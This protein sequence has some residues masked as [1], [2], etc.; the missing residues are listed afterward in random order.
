MKKRIPISYM[1]TTLVSLGATINT[2]NT[3][4]YSNVSKDDDVKVTTTDAQGTAPLKGF[5]LYMNNGYYY[6]NNAEIITS[7]SKSD[8]IRTNG[9]S[10]YFYANNLKITAS[11]DHADAI[12]MASSNSNT[13]Y[14]D[15]IF[16]KENTE[17]SSSSGVTVRANNYFNENSKSVAILSDNAVITNKYLSNANNSSDTQGYGVYAGNRDKDINNLGIFD[18]LAGKNNNTKG[19]SYIFISDN[20]EIESNAKKGHAVY[21]NKG[22]TIQLGDSAKIN[23]NGLDAYAIFASTEQQGTYTDNIRPGKVYLE[24]GAALRAENSTYVIQAKG[25]DSVIMSGYLNVPVI[26]S[27]YVRG[28]DIN[29]N[30]NI[31][32]PSSG[33]FDIKGNISAIEGGYVFL[34]MSNSSK[35]IGSTEIDTGKNSGVDLKISGSNSNW[36]MNKDS[37]LT[38][39]TLSDEAVLSLYRP[40][41]FIPVSYT[42]EGTV[43]NGGIIDFSSA[44]GNSFDT[45]TIKGN[46]NGNNG[47]II[48]DIELND[49]N[50]ETDKLVIIGD[51]SGNTKVKVNNIGG[52]GTETLEGIELISVG[53]NSDGQFEKSERI[54]AGAYEYFLN[55]GNGNTTDTKKWYLNS[56]LVPGINPPVDSIKPVDPQIP[57]ANPKPPAGSIK[58]QKVY[59]PESGSYLAN[60]AAVNNL[61]VHSLYDRLGDPQYTDSLSDKGHATS[62]WIR[63]IGG[64]N[65]FKDGSKQ[66]NTHGKTYILQVGSDIAQWSTNELNRYHLGIMGGY[67]FNHNSTNS[68]ITNYKSQGKSD[69]YNIGVYSTWF[70]NNEDRSGL[71][72]DSW[73]TYSWFDS[74]VHGED[75][76]K[77][78]YSYKG[79]TASIEGGYTFKVDREPTKNEFFVQPRAQAIYMGVKTKDHTES[80][81]TVVEFSGDDN[82]QT[83]LG[84]RI[85]T[86][87][88]DIKEAEKKVFQPFAEATWIHNQKDFGVSM[89]NVNNKVDVKDLG[90]IKF[91]TEIKFNQNF[92][93]WGYLSYRWGK[94]KY[95]DAS[96]SLGLKYTF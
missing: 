21:A 62:M 89:N 32:N 87:N 44:N 10:N 72:M 70:D 66:L 37:S 16:V 71:Y 28:G 35:F 33:I 51:T 88:L 81:G 93:T 53:G 24:G 34:N 7:G 31:I 29:I 42:L 39:I 91:G 80:N 61:F 90:E 69:G 26:D 63:N 14:T 84:L 22:G 4:Y 17:L 95:S 77:E 9:G 82:I 19:K 27:T 2:N 67:G 50:S 64:N 45:F 56:S 76:D 75:L 54:V 8:A 73:L 36:E 30:D 5:G 94:N 12:N 59:R 57:P 52:I 74:E 11:G 58:D 83:R 3:L 25:K 20:S 23:A 18:I 78:N 96:V 49:D 68:K 41:N 92:D 48:F 1:I 13:K 6:L 15:L 60:N 46:Y 65:T 47:L 43:N 86:S 38:S 85:Y 40:S 79:L 55:R